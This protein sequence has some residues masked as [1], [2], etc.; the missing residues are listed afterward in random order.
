MYGVV[1]FG[2][3]LLEEVGPQSVQLGESLSHEP[4]E[5]R[6][7]LLL[8][9]AFDDHLWQL[10]LFP[11]W[12]LYFHQLVARLFKVQAGHD[13]K[14]NSPAQIDKVGVRLVFDLDSTIFLSFFV[15]V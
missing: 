12:Q 9:T 13:G 11:G 10:V 2:E 1:V 8:R 15:I 6:V 7:C 4:K 3:C 14:I 5:F